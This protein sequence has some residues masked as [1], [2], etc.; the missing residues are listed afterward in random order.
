MM[1]A[2]ELAAEGKD[3]GGGRSDSGCEAPDSAPSV[4]V[5]QTPRAGLVLVLMQRAAMKLMVETAM[6][7]EEITVS[8]EGTRPWTIS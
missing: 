3:S 7:R 1:D 6:Q 4:L 5:L 2:R 8:T